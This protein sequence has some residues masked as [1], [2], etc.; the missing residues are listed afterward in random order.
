MILNYQLPLFLCLNLKRIP[1]SLS[2][3]RGR[4]LAPG[5]P[6]YGKKGTINN[7]KK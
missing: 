2:L 1:G 7:W 4:V 6:R 5:L 3:P